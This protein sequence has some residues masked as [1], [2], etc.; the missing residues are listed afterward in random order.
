MEELELGKG[1]LHLMNG[2]L[3]TVNKLEWSL[4]LRESV[5]SDEGEES[6]GLTGAGWHLEEAVALGVE[7][8][9]EFKHISVLLWAQ[10]FIRD[11]NYQLSFF[12]GASL[13]HI[14]RH[15]NAAAHGLARF[16]FRVDSDY[17]WRANIPGPIHA[18]VNELI[19]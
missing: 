11:I 1:L 10:R 16:A 15:S 9:L 3:G 18:I 12:P 6:N 19:H 13:N 5:A 4:G 14:S 7:R 2:S 8:S 17:V